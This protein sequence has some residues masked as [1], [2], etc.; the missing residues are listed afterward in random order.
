MIMAEVI[1]KAIAVLHNSKKKIEWRQLS[2]V[3]HAKV[4]HSQR[5]KDKKKRSEK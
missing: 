1:L 4:L 2:Y 5:E 3:S